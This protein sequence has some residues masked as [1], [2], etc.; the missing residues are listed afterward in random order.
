MGGSLG[1][2]ANPFAAC[3]ILHAP[4]IIANPAATIGSCACLALGLILAGM[5]ANS[6]EEAKVLR[7]STA[8]IKGLA[9]AAHFSLLD[10]VKSLSKTYRLSMHM[11]LNI[12]NAFFFQ[13]QKCCPYPRAPT[14]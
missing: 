11:S 5:L 4:S 2:T 10:S 9:A 8:L 7:S 1:L 14:E 6:G 12:T 3:I 13:T